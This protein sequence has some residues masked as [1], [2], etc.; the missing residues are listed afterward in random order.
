MLLDASSRSWLPENPGRL[1][2]GALVA[3]FASASGPSALG[4]DGPLGLFDGHGDVGSPQIAG[5]ATYNAV[6]QEYTLR[7]A[8][9]NMWAQR[10]EFHFVWKKMKGDFILQA[11]VELVGA[12]VDPHRKL[13]F[14]VRST[15]DADSPYADVAVHGDGL[16]SLQYRRTKGAITEQV[17]STP[18]GARRHPARAEGQHL[19]PLRGPVRRSLHHERARG[20]RPGR[21]GLRRPLPLLAQ[22]RRGGEG[23]LSRRAPHPPRQGRLRSLPRL[24]RKRPGDPRRGD[25]PSAGGPELGPALRGAQLDPRRQR[26]HLQHE[27]PRARDEGASLSLRSR[28]PAG[29]AHRH[30]HR[31]PQQQRPRAVLRRQHARH[32]RPEHRAVAN[33]R[34]SPCPPRGEPPSA[35]RR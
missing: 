20:S 14:I 21:R 35:S 32:Q 23:G 34:S 12:G 31:Q 28:H 5:S 16:T 22:P 1:V 33:P 18:E 3:M 17:Q 27:R 19:H 15:L 10:D 25:R 9:V 2:L 30:R 13:G 29:D 11:R 6:S 26:P 24:H 4:Q 7:A 8:G